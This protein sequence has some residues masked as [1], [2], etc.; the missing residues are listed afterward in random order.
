MEA[1]KSKIGLL[2][3]LISP[4]EMEK[5]APKELQAAHK[6]L[7]EGDYIRAKTIANSIARINRQLNIPKLDE[8]LKVL[9][10]KIRKKRAEA[11]KTSSL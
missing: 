8:E 4:A 1:E 10:E 11:R 2:S 5:E 6:L 9:F 7:E 3:G